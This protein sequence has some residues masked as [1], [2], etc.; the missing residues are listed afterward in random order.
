MCFAIAGAVVALLDGWAS[1]APST[2][3]AASSAQALRT[4]ADRWNQNN[5]LSW[6]SMSARISIRALTARERSAVLIPDHAQRRCTLSLARRPGDNTWLCRIDNVGG[7]DCPLV[8]SDGM[9][10]LKDANATTD[11]RG[12]LKLHV[13]LKGTHAVRPLAWQRRYPHVDGFILPWTHAG[14][15]RPGLRF[16]DAERGSCGFFVEHRVPRSGGRCLSGAG[17]IYEPCFPQRRVFLA[18]HL[19]ACGA[20]G[21]TSFTRWSV[22]GRL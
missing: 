6:G 7:Y 12:I 1:A 9:P 16:D 21:Y 20:P 22:T 4:C 5:M 3:P 8:T 14:R 19:A 15:L 18:R 11:R 13:S 17:A 10:P 2:R